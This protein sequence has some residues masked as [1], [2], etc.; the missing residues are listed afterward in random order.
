M[1]ADVGPIVDR[2]L[3]RALRVLP[4]PREGSGVIGEAEP[5]IRPPES[6]GQPLARPR[7]APREKV[8]AESRVAPT[9]PLPRLP[10]L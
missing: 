5:L 7:L 8:D 1:C 10:L 9:P 6:T 3:R 4:A 2:G